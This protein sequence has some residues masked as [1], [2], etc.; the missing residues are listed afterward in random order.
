MTSRFKSFPVH[1][2]EHFPTVARYRR[3]EEW[4]RLVSA[5]VGADVTLATLSPWTCNDRKTGLK[6]F[7]RRLSRHL[8]LSYELSRP[9]QRQA[10]QA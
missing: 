10:F 9:D 5:G 2:G 4:Q 6:G 8:D 3:A 7:I 1:T